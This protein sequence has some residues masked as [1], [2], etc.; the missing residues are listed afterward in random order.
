MFFLKE[1]FTNR[2][3]IKELV[4]RD[5]KVRYSRP[6]LGFLWAFL[7]P[8]LTVVIFYFVFSVILR[9]H[10][11]E[12]PFVLYLIS[13]VFSWR[14]FQDSLMGSVTS[15]VDN[16][17]MIREANFAHYLMPLSI[18]LANGINFLPSLVLMII[19][20]S[21]VLRGL[22]L[23]IGWLPVVL[24]VHLVL[25]TG[26]AVFFSLLYVKWRDVK[27]LLEAL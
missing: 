10:I 27:Y 20:S 19:S 6:A 7:S 5:L 16:K 18:V 13:G 2:F 9:V 1:I 17:N 15:L 25:T 26:L 3:L 14:F 21:L 22:P 11:Q 4:V 12:A 24:A 8:F 23:F